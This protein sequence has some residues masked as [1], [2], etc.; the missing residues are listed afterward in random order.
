[1]GA[2]TWMLVGSDS[3]ARDALAAQP[4]IDRD[5]TLAKCRELFPRAKLTT[6][7]DGD[8]SYTCPRD[9]ELCAGCFPGVSVFAAE[10]FAIDYPSRLPQAFV[11]SCGHK[12]V[13]LHA[14]HSVVD[15]FAYAFWQDG[16]LIRALSLSPDSGVLEDFG[17]RLDFEEPYWAGSHPAVED[18]EEESYPFPFHPLELGEATLLEFFGYQLEG[19]I[20]AMVFDPFDVPLMRFER[21]RPWWRFWG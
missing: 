3:S 1:M 20:D 8:L 19:A 15:W 17:P 16:K 12:N 9:S 14:M 21:S 11:D 10:E 13:V 4:R 5:K 18:P 6:Q 7:A 2:K